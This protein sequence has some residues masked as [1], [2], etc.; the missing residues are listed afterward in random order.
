MSYGGCENESDYDARLLAAFESI[1]TSL[2]YAV[3]PHKVKLTNPT[4]AVC[5][6]GY[7]IGFYTGATVSYEG[8]LSLVHPQGVLVY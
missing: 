3:N 6:C 7:M 2:A 4:T 1:A 8:Q 5:A